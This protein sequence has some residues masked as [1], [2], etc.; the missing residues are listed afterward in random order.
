MTA[1]SERAEDHSSNFVEEMLNEQREATPGLKIATRFPPEP[2]GYLHLGHAKSICLNFGLA[3]KFGGTCNLGFDDTNPSTEDIEFVQSIQEDVKWLGFNWNGKPLFTS[4][5]FEQLY[6]WAVQLIKAG[7][8]YIDER[9]VDVIRETR[10]NF[11]KPGVNAPSR[12]S[13]VEENLA[14][15]QKMRAGEYDEGAAVLRAKIDMQ[16]TNV[17]LRDPLMYRV[18]KKTH[19]RTGDD[20]CIYPMYDWA[21]GLSDAIEGI[22]HSICTLEFEDHRPLYDW[23]INAVGIENPPHQTEFARLNLSYTILSKR[24]LQKLVSEGHVA[25]WNDPRMPTLA[26]LRRRGYTPESLRLFAERIGVSRRDGIVDV[27]LLEHTLREDLNLRSPRMMGVL[28]PLK[29]TITNMAEDESYEVEARNHQEVESLGSRRLCLSKHLFIDHEDFK[30]EAPKKWFRLT[31]GQEVRLRFGGL[32]RC[33]DIVKDADGNVIE[34]LCTWDPESLGGNAA[35]GRKV[36][37]TIH[38]VNAKTAVDADVYLYDRLFTE[39]NP[40]KETE[41]GDFLQFVNPESLQILRGAK[42][43]PSLIEL[44]PETPVQFERLG[45]FV[46]DAHS[47]TIRF[48]RTITLKD[49]WAKVEKKS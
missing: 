9:P 42:L 16:S 49:G 26:G 8:A 5:Y 40:S 19:H 3:Q 45:Y 38:W 36:K 14:K 17:N 35:D 15:F 2:N 4:D 32:V 28:S 41:T 43:E 24:K 12:D 39:E 31:P 47:D 6:E 13:S 22:S 1:E 37:G 20:W 27:A 46:R 18:M 34:L 30:E 11:F 48:N 7:Q 44:A 23:F 29:L 33:N 25:G 21:H 10:G